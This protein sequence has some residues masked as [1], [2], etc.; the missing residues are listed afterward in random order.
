MTSIEVY[1]SAQGKG[2]QKFIEGKEDKP[3]NT[4]LINDI[5]RNFAR[6]HKAMLKFVSRQNPKM[7]VPVYKPL[8]LP[9]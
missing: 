2:I 7:N 4:K 8:K 3:L 5:A 1:K 6:M 9:H